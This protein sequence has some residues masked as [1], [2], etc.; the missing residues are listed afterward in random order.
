M[1]YQKKNLWD[2]PMKGI[3]DQ[4]GNVPEKPPTMREVRIGAGWKN[5]NVQALIDSEDGKVQID[6][7][8]NVITC[9]DEMDPKVQKYWEDLG[10]KKILFNGDDLGEK[11]T[12]LLPLSSLKPENADRKYPLFFVLHGG[13]TPP[14]EMEGYGFCEPAREDE[15]IIIIPM[16]FAHENVLSIYHYVIGKYPVDR[17]RVYAASYCGGN[18]TNEVA[19]LY[20]ELFAA[21][22]P[23]GNPLR[24]NYKPV[25]W[26]PDYKRVRRLSLPCIHI[27][28][29][30]DLTQL[31]PLYVTGDPEKSEDPNYPGRTATMPLAKREYKVNCLRDMLFV[32]DCKDVSAED[33]YACEQSDDPVIRAV[34][35]PADETEVREIYGQKHYIAKF[36]NSDGNPWLQIVAV[37]NMPHLPN[38]SLGVLAWEFMRQFRRN[39]ETGEIEV[40]GA[41]KPAYNRSVGEFDIDRYRHDYGSRASGYTTAWKGHGKS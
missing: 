27:D 9:E 23:C 38:A 19:L 12:C 34:G 24:E 7:W 2:M 41:I 33:V 3:R 15:P 31:L 32:F 35:A 29:L 22:A 1:D 25:L 6:Q 21:I 37:E 17:G 5:F 13:T 4:K 28:G 11:W 20:P 30:D 14:F 36:R 40:I 16:N 10:W 26:Y 18:R 8:E 39:T